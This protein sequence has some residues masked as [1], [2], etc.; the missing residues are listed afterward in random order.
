MK[1][2]EW[3]FGYVT[4]RWRFPFTLIREQHEDFQVA[5]EPIR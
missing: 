5:L 2:I 4:Y 3:C 1:G